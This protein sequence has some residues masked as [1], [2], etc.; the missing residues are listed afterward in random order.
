MDLEILEA[1]ALSEDR[2]AALAQLLPG[3]AEHDYYRALQLQHR[4]ALDEV[5]PILTQWN[6]RHGNN[7]NALASQLRRRQQLYRAMADG[8]ARDTALHQLRDELGIAHNHQAEVESVD[9]TRPTQLPGALFDPARLL[10]QATQN[11]AQL[12]EVTDEGIFELVDAELEAGRRRAF[13]A[14]LGHTPGEAIVERI[15]E[16]LEYRGSQGFGSVAVHE[17]LT[18]AQLHALAARRP[19]LRTQV[20]WIHAVVTR[21]QPVSDVDLAQDLTARAA[22]LHELW[23]FV[24]GLSPV[25]S[26]LKAHVLWH[27]LDTARRRDRAFD[28]AVIGAYLSLPRQAVYAVAV[29]RD[30]RDEVVQFNADFAKVTRLGA[31][32][33]DEE[34]IRDAI[35]RD[36]A[37]AEGFAPWLERTWL[38]AELASAQLLAGATGDAADRAT[39]VLGPARA[40]A[41]RERV[42]LAWCPHN[43][44]ELAADAPVALDVDVK[45]V[46]ELLVKVFRIDPLA[47][48]QHHRREVDT[49]LDLDGLAASHEQVLRFTEPAIRRVRRRIELASCQRPGTYVVDLIG[50]GTA[51]RAVIRKGRLRHTMRIGA[52]GHVV[53]IFDD[54]GQPRPDARA[55]I[56]DRA[57][58]PD[59]DG[60]LVVPFSTSPGRTPMLLSAGDLAEVAHLELTSERAALSLALAL[61]R[62]SLSAGRTARAI[63]RLGLSIGGAPASLK[64]LK[65]PTWDVAMTD[66]HG[67]TTT[68]SFPLVLDDTDAA[69]LD[70]PVGD[71]LA[72]LALSVR[73]KLE[74]RSTQREED[75]VVQR[76]IPVARMYGQTGTDALYLA[77]TTDGWVISALG[78]GGEPRAHRP[79]AI[80]V[81]HRWA[82]TELRKELATDARGR[83]VLGALPGV[84]RIAAT[85]GGLSQQWEVDAPP[86]PA[87]SLYAPV[88]ED[89]IVHLPAT[90][91]AAEVVGRLSLVELR[92]RAPARHVQPEL[93]LLAGAI[94][95]RGLAAGEYQLRAPSVPLTTIY[96][97]AAT[98][99]IG[100]WAV[101]PRTLVEVPR[102][103]PAIAAIAVSDTEVSIALRGADADATRVHVIATRFLPAGVEPL[104]G[105]PA[106]VPSWRS[107]GEPSARYV[108]GRELGDEYRYVLERRNQP[109]YPGLLLDKPSLLLNPWARRT[110][111]TDVQTAK[112]RGGFMQPGARPMM[113]ASP[114]AG[115]GFG[116]RPTP[117]DDA[118]VG[119]DFLPEPPAVLANLVADDAGVVRVPRAQL[120]GAASLAIIVDDPAGRSERRVALPEPATTPRELRLVLALAPERHATQAKAIAPLVAGGQLVIEDRATARVHLLD[121]VARAHAYLLA[122]R[123][124][125]TLR[126]FAFVTRWHEIDL[127][128]RH[129][130]YS[131][132]ACH[133]LHLFLYFKD[134][135]FFDAVIRPSLAHKR[136]KTFVDHWLLDAELAPYTEPPQLSR[137]N[138][139]ERALLAWRLIGDDA[140]PRLFGDEIA[141]QAPDP[142]RD[143]RL[144]DALLNAQALDGDDRLRP[145][146]DKEMSSELALDELADDTSELSRSAPAASYGGP[147][148]PSRARSASPKLSKKSSGPGGP[149]GLAADLAR[150]GEVAPMFR[151]ADK[152][153]EWAEH[154]WWRRTPDQSRAEMIAANR[155]WRDLAAHA[156]GNTGGFLSRWLGLATGS[157]AEAMVAL[158]VTDLPFVP[159]AHAIVQDGPR[160]VITAAG[161]ALAGT[162]QLVDAPMAPAGAPLVVGMTYVRADDRYEYVDGQR[163][164]RYV[165]AFTAGV[166]YVCQIVVA[167]PS[168]QRQRVSA[169]VQVPRG[170]I[171]VGGGK[172][173]ETLDVVLEPY[174][175]HG[176]EIAFYWP[177]A[178][179]WSQFP[180]HVSRDGAIVAAATPRAL[181]VHT[182]DAAPDRASWSYLSQRGT[183]GEVVAYLATANLAALE[184]TRVAWRLRELAA[185]RAILGA[186]EARRVYD[187]TLW[188]YA[189]LHRDAPRIRTWLRAYALGGSL[190]GGPVL[191]MI[192]LDDEAIGRYEHLELAPLTNARAHRLG[193]KLKILNDGLARQYERFL[194]LVAHRP[195]PT[196]ED[197]LAATHY[198]LAQDR[199]APAL[200]TLARVDQTAPPFG[201]A[202]ARGQAPGGDASQLAERMQY[203]YLTG[204]VAAVTGDVPR[205]REVA[206]RWA[207]GE[208]QGGLID[209]W[210]HKFGALAQMLAELDGAATAAVDPRS[211]DQQQAEL[212]AQQPSFDLAADHDGIV[213][214]SH[215][216]AALE[217]RLFEMDIELLFSRQP[218]VQ[219]DVSRFSF[220]E[221]G[222]REAI[223]SPPPEL[224]VAWPAP[225]RGKNVVVE[226]VGAGLRR[227]KV[228]YA[229]D[230]IT[231]LA[232]QYGQLRVLRSS[233]RL[234]LPAT[235]V[236]VYAKKRHGAVEFYK[237]G[238]TDLRG[239][240]DYATL[241]TT[242]LDHV[243]RFAI[244][245]C[246]D[247]AGAAILE[248]PPPAR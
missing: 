86:L 211:R 172:P 89:V 64:L 182:G 8:P 80:A 240:F 238:Y 3:S 57:Y 212:A 58:T 49:Q 109:R 121:S 221:P 156:S 162:S 230:L 44:T 180:V 38:E 128:E 159:A 135:A 132:Y 216:V 14:R 237:D 146:A 160:L 151:A 219:S 218:F 21:M 95:I 157:F 164:D 66:R 161:N 68:K 239:W 194:A 196:A 63:A 144:I 205:A 209:R 20:S 81:V 214:H 208:S 74:L 147:P 199:I 71:E 201:G 105:G 202:A 241:S 174:G 177:A 61:D 108:A 62:Q 54:A 92:G 37:A 190:A 111:T 181:E 110:T 27:L 52:A 99:R 29:P 179:A 100:D 192:G 244:L 70:W 31:T 59:A 242:D 185:Y 122:L 87:V 231:N 65:Q 137:L 119:Y 166:V 167:N 165:E 215:H 133:E 197:L 5:D 175:T 7:A 117:D 163:L 184:L 53:T 93:E 4:G 207:A 198:L 233:D 75:V 17:Q 91:S 67:V 84:R 9:P 222:H 224:R 232:H 24:S 39:R 13:L 48:F 210:R 168:S 94:A 55:W 10:Q 123:D 23:G 234:P 236:K 118:F 173:T 112:P 141:N 83:L 140:L 51:S 12:G 42:E 1:L 11:D 227:A 28:P 120:A 79:I 138:A 229:N 195:A 150:I 97:T 69:V 126:E 124:D 43:P 103:A 136:V 183:T 178:G 22:F 189:F 149:A 78:K 18:L 16:D 145:A 143:A 56:G 82:D 26:S 101:A 76:Q 2:S 41:L 186:L 248:A 155:L 188:G 206:A 115:G 193:S 88:G 153:Q 107:D 127:A 77:H 113:E 187:E 130:L 36:P 40:A 171:A 116:G 35:Q 85:L 98:Q 169:L 217:L 19:V 191:D 228:H 200:A 114:A 246:S 176:R 34:L 225:L 129:S 102:F 32:G 220:I 226:A 158:A 223:T 50:N 152:T 90:R 96:L 47:Y 104:R 235:Y 134:R 131:K 6:D 170:S 245:V 243:D 46:D 213:V 106:V 125:A 73:G 30:R 148:A 203:D 204:Y 25:A 60:Q 45:H 247:T 154:N 139:V 72:E 33:S 15:A 142:A